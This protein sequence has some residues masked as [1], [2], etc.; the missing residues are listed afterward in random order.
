ML[1]PFS[2]LLTRCL[3]RTAIQKISPNVLSTFCSTMLEV[4]PPDELLVVAPKDAAMQRTEGVCS[5]LAQYAQVPLPRA[6][7]DDTEASVKLIHS[8][9]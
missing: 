6:M 2:V 7:F 8:G 9:V 3:D 4:H 1:F 5:A